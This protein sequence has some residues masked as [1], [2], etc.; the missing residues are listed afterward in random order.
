MEKWNKEFHLDD[1]IELINCDFHETPIESNSLDGVYMCESMAHSPDYKKLCRE[2]FRVLKPGGKYTGF[3]WDLTEKYDENNPEHVLIRRKLER[4]LAI[5]EMVKMS[6]FAE[7]LKEAG[8]EI[9]KQRDHGEFA[10]KLGA[11][12]WWY[13]VVEDNLSERSS[14]SSF[15]YKAFM[16]LQRVCMGSLTFTIFAVL[17]VLEKLSFVPQGT[18]SCNRLLMDSLREGM[19][20]GAKEDIFTPMHY[21]LAQKPYKNGA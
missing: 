6:V 20:G 12:P 17:W 14:L 11:K 9:I 3:N 19:Q 8:F 21:W 10:R 1:R 13:I 5:P 18:A 4:G 16:I 7:A 15:V 2:V